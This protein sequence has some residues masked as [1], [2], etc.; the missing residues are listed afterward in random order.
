MRG[1]SFHVFACFASRAISICYKEKRCLEE[2]LRQSEEEKRGSVQTQTEM[3]KGFKNTLDPVAVLSAPIA[4]RA[5]GVANMAKIY[6]KSYI[7]GFSICSCG[8][9]HGESHC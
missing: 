9:E 1:I 7:I 6:Y 4:G 2:R 8:K 5:A 3:L